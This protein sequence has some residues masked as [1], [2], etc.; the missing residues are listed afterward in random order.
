MIHLSSPCHTV[1][2]GEG[3]AH[4][5]ETEEQLQQRLVQLLNLP[6]VPH[7]LPHWEGQLDAGLEERAGF[8]AL[9]LP[10]LAESLSELP[11]HSR[12]ALGPGFLQGGEEGEDIAADPLSNVGPPNRPEIDLKSHLL[13]NDTPNEAQFT[14]EVPGRAAQPACNHSHTHGHTHSHVHRTA[15]QRTDKRPPQPE[16]SQSVEDT[17]LDALLHSAGPPPAAAVGTP[18]GLV[19][20]GRGSPDQATRREGGGDSKLT[21]AELDDILDDLLT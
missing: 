8:L 20:G 17:E 6:S 2:A 12:L 14:F 10:K 21:T 18:P 7:P 1:D 9:D 13:R 4:I 11:L 16:E 15:V 5:L 19:G 3:T